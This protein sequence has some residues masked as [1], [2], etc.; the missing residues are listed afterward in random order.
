MKK[1]ISFMFMAIGG[2]FMLSGAGFLCIA[3]LFNK[4]D[5][6]E[7]VDFILPDEDYQLARGKKHDA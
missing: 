6:D 1:S 5:T 3:R 2:V 4:E 7:F